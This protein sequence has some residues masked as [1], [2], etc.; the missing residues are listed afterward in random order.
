MRHELAQERGPAYRQRRRKVAIVP[1]PPHRTRE[2]LGLEVAVRVR[3][4][5]FDARR[6]FD[7]R[8]EREVMA[9]R[10][11]G[12]HMHVELDALGGARVRRDDQRLR[13]LI[14]GRHEQGAHV[15]E[16]CGARPHGEALLEV[17][18]Y[19]LFFGEQRVTL[20]AR[21]DHV[22]SHTR[23]PSS[24][25][26]LSV[27]RS[28]SFGSV[29]SRSAKISAASGSPMKEARTARPSSTTVATERSCSQPT[30]ISAK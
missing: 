1:A 12:G 14:R 30:I 28:L 29:R 6:A 25:Y 23:R 27:A 4:E 15:G 17:V 26:S 13:A 20:R 7:D 10:D 24:R 11:V 5:A 22:G 18:A 16:G 9:E 8:D 3:V 19:T 21:D 2:A